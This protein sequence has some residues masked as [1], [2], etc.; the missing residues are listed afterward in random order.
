MKAL[1]I[2]NFHL[3]FRFWHPRNLVMYTYMIYH[4]TGTFQ[5]KADM[6]YHLLHI[7]L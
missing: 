2:Y 3:Y 1:L 4:Q 7:F 5:I 6:M